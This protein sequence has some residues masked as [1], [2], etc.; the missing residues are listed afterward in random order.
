MSITELSVKR[1]TL[2][3]VLFTILTL[4]GII[5]YTTLSYELLP[6][7]TSP[8]LSIVTVY[9]G[10]SPGEVEN[11]VTIKVE[12]AV[13]SLE[14]VESIKSIS[15]ES[16]SSVTIQL[17]YGSDVDLIL[18][19]AQRKMS[20]I[21]SSLPDQAEQPTVQKF[22][23]DELPIMRLGVSSNISPVL[24]NE[25][26]EENV[27]ETLS[28]IDGVAKVEMIGGVEREIKINVDGDKL[29][30]FNL[31]ILQ[32]TQAITGANLD[33][34]TGKIK[35]DEQQVLVRLSGKFQSVRDIENL[36]I[37]T[38]TGAAPILIKDIA[39]VLD[40]EKETSSLSRI[41]GTNSI[42]LL[43]SK[44]SDGNTV[45]VAEDVKKRIAQLEDTY[46]DENLVFTTA[47]DSSE[48]TLEAANAVIHDLV[49]AV[50]LVAFIM[51]L[52]LHSL[53]DAIIVMVS[54]PVSIVTTFIVM[55]L[56]GFSLNL[57]T[58]LGLSLVVGIL[59]DDSI[60][61]IENIHA[62]M[63]QGASA[64]DAAK[65]TWKQIGLSVMSITLTIIVVFVP[66]TFVTGIIADLLRQ[67]ALVVAFA[68]AI[69]FVVSFTL[70]PFLS[71]RFSKAIQLN[72]N[73]WMHKPLIWFETGL[74]GLINGYKAL[75]EWTLAHKRWTILGIFSLVIA[76]FFL[77]SVGLIG[78]EFVKNGDNGEFLVTIEL[79]KESTFEETNQTTRLVEELLLKDDL[80]SNI[81]ASVGS[82]GGSSA[83]QTTAY[84]AEINAKMISPDLRTISS[85]EYAQDIKMKLRRDFV[86]AK[87][88]VTPVSMVGGGTAAPV[89]VILKGND[90]NTVLTFA[91]QALLEISKVAGTIEEELTVDAGNPEISVSVDR[92]KMALLGLTMDVVGGTMQNAF[93]GNTDNKY[94]DG[95]NEYDI[96][97]QLDQ[98]DRRNIDDIK[99][100]TFK[101]PQGHLIQLQQFADVVFANGPSRLERDDKQ[102]SVTLTSQIIGRPEGNVGADVQAAIAAMDMP[103]GVEFTMGGNLDS[104]QEA[105]IDLGVA[106]LMSIVLVYLIMVAL[107]DSYVYPFVVMFSVPVALIGAL[108]ALALALENLSIFTI[109]GIIMLVGL[110]IKNAILIV[111]FT[112]QLKAEGKGS[113]EAVVE[114]GVARFR[115]VLMT[116]IAMV[117]AMIPIAIATGAGSEWKNGLAIVLIGGLTSSMIFTIVLVPVTYLS[118]DI[119]IDYT[120]RKFKKSPALVVEQ[121][122]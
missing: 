55:S 60:V 78:S 14:G 33:F 48:F 43:I 102:T 93:S 68:T 40:T 57:M 42:G 114:A 75:L 3:V 26:V 18:Q 32:V 50:I 105:F 41:N 9:P 58:L 77:F 31:S 39:E 112:N 103:D 121:V 16:V 7:I 11:A 88:T 20:N 8:V 37:Q 12:D 67:F 17:K 82:V 79:P 61:V 46:A 98:F 2:V 94:R 117:I 108:L 107:Y 29:S 53:R 96:N 38:S 45:Q 70:T 49:I 100:L 5:S 69:S 4:L 119:I 35:D 104:Q 87:F 92:E 90:L 54:I 115:P 122:L 28:R 109:L 113:F 110:V 86:G 80:I 27:K 25:F 99:K 22:S 15:M 65:D 36:A 71:S 21:L 101:N 34:P 19:D 23:L 63:H 44:Q 72:N 56:L 1:P 47:Q 76:S 95:Q 84:K 83:G 74:N 62:R 30:A 97:I 120:K 52:F 91:D 116:T 13:S 10:A 64:W 24:F 89:Q 73:N 106:L 6:K 66:I 111:D 51:L 59:V 85:A 118:F 81:F